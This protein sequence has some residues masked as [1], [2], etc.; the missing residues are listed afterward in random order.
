[1]DPCVYI[2]RLESH[3][4]SLLPKAGLETIDISRGVLVAIGESD[5]RRLFRSLGNLPTL[6]RMT[7]CGGTGS[8]TAI[9]TRVFAASL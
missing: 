1:M 4:S 9:H 5:Q 7:L 8:P 6:Q 2:E 3:A